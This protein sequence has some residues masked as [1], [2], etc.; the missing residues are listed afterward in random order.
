MLT[1]WNNIASPPNPL[2][3]FVMDNTV[4]SVRI[5]A[6][7]LV[8]DNLGNQI[9]SLNFYRSGCGIWNPIN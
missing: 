9:L 7:D 6:E 8:K 2:D 4:G 1:T 5:L 3:I